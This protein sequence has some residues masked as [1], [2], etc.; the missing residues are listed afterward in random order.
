L[1]VR[2]SLASKDAYLDAEESMALKAVPEQRA[3]KTQDT[4]RINVCRSEV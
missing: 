2:L 4:E 1:G 3:M